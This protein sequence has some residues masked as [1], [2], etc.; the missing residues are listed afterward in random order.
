MKTHPNV[1]CA[2]R[3]YVGGAPTGARTK[4]TKHL[5]LRGDFTG[6]VSP[7]RAMTTRPTAWVRPQAGSERR[8]PVK[9]PGSAPRADLLLGENAIERDDVQV[10]VQ[11]RVRTRALHHLEGAA[12]CQPPP[13]E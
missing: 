7:S 2:A 3:C 4:A 12:T 5:D 6:E 13:F 10:R 9:P 8:N 1:R 11:L